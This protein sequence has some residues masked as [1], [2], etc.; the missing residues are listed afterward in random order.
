M[1]ARRHN[2]QLQKGTQAN[3]DSQLGAMRVTSLHGSE[4]QIMCSLRWA[5]PGCCNRLRRRGPPAQDDR[6]SHMRHQMHRVVHSCK[7]TPP[8]YPA[9]SP[10]ARN[11]RQP[12]RPRNRTATEG[13]QRR[14]TPHSSLLSG[15]GH[16]VRLGCP[17]QIRI[18]VAAGSNMTRVASVKS[19]VRGKYHGECSLWEVL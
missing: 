4:R 1:S 5:S 10:P 14:S 9:F 7:E 16:S 19:A 15:R 8:Q 17:F 11:R 13:S 3:C 6:S 18:A 2:K 12:D